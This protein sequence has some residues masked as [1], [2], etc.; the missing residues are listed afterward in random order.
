MENQPEHPT[1]GGHHRSTAAWP[2]GGRFLVW[3]PWGMELSQV[4]SYIFGLR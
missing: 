2:P 1:G 4:W 3:P